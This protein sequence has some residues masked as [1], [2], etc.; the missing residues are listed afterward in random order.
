M[1]E[2]SRCKSKE[3]FIR[4][5]GNNTGLYCSKCGKWIKWLSKN[6][7]RLAEKQIED[8][9][10]N[11]LNTDEKVFYNEDIRHKINK[12]KEL[13]S[14]AEAEKDVDTMTALQ[15]AIFQLL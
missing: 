5:S 14:R 11:Q 13:Y 6:E 2:C 12:L 4:M 8:A 1:F 9:A 3:I 7:K 15:W 10:T